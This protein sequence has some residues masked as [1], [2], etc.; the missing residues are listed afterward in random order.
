MKCSLIGAAHLG[1]YAHF[2]SSW[3]RTVTWI[4]SSSRVN[5]S[6]FFVAGFFWNN[7]S[8]LHA[9]CNIWLDWS[10]QVRW[11]GDTRRKISRTSCPESISHRFG[12]QILWLQK[13]NR[14]CLPC[15]ADLGGCWL[16]QRSEVHRFSNSGACSCGCRCSLAGVQ[17][18][19]HHWW[20]SHHCSHFRKPSRVHQIFSPG[21]RGQHHYWFRR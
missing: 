10:E 3:K 1:K 17:R 2:F 14:F 18:G 6:F 9:V 12:D 16:G 5:D 7:R 15:T 8:L 21:S 11:V 19:M 13:T 4:E 20:P